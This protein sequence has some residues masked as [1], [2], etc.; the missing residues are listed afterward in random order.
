MPKSPMKTYD[1]QRVSGMAWARECRAAVVYRAM[2]A[3][4]LAA[5]ERAIMR[6][7]PPDNS[8]EVNTPGCRRRYQ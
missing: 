5:A 7:I 2:T 8:A 1:G 4:R 3:I 6:T